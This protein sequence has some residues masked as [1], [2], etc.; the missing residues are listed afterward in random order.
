MR[1]GYVTIKLF[2]YYAGLKYD[3]AKRLLE[4]LCK[5]KNPRLRKHKE[6]TTNLYVPIVK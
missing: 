5:G 6:G 3:S 2:A 4:K 1:R